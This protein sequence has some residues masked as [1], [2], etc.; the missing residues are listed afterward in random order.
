ILFDGDIVKQLISAPGDVVLGVD[1]DWREHYRLRTQHPPTDAEKVITNGSRVVRVDRR[2]PN[3]E[4]MG[5]FIGVARF[6][7]Q[8]AQL[9]RE[10]YHRNRLKFAGLPFREAPIFEKAYLIHMLQEMLEQGVEINQVEDTGQY[11]EIDTQED[12][13]LAQKYWK[14]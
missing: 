10:H 1:T 3:D 2:I 13:A 7:V 8:G 4:A 12:M 14:G 9:L 11:R 6:S 5:E